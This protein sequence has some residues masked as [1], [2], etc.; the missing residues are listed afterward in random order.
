MKKWIGFYSQSRMYMYWLY[1]QA[2]PE[3]EISFS[4]FN[5]MTAG[6]TVK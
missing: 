2:N 5:D 6:I 3:T 1:C 4:E